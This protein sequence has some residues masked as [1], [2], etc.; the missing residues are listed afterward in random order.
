MDPEPQA[1]QPSPGPGAPTPQPGR[2]PRGTGSRWRPASRSR[3]GTV[4]A[5]VFAAALA[6]GI[7]F[8]DDI[9]QVLTPPAAP[10]GVSAAVA[11]NTG[12]QSPG[13]MPSRVAVAAPAPQPGPL[14]SSEDAAPVR[15]AGGSDGLVPYPQEA[16]PTAARPAARTAAQLAPRPRRRFQTVPHLYDL[17]PKPSPPPV[18]QDQPIKTNELRAQKPPPLS[19]ITV[20]KARIQIFV[21][22]D[23]YEDDDTVNIYLNGRLVYENLVL[24]N[25]RR[26]HPP[27]PL[28]LDLI[29]GANVLTVEAVNIGDPE[30]NR[31]MHLQPYNSAAIKFT[32]VVRGYIEQGWW[33]GMKEKASMRII[34]APRYGVVDAH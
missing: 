25:A 8:K 15:E 12:P 22:D 2:D 7:A 23:N 16:A 21:W 13:G 34:Y 19:D 18:V 1:D 28:Q 14:R 24:K 26:F 5:A 17:N 33:L 32:S 30:I 3:I 6:A 11:R 10:P 31:R 4:A 9:R 20:N 29:A 27:A